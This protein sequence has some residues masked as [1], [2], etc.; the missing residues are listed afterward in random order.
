MDS[1]L[2]TWVEFSEIP[3]NPVDLYEL[4]GYG[5][6]VPAGEVSEIIEDLIKTAGGNCN[7]RIGYR[8]FDGEI[9]DSRQVRVENIIFAPGRIITSALRDS[10]L[11]AVFTATAGDDFDNWLGRI[12]SEGDIVRSYIASS[13]GSVIAESLVTMLMNRLERSASAEGLSVS[14]NYSPG[15]C[16]WHLGEQKKLLSLLENDNTGIRLNDSCLMI[17]IKSVSGLTGIGRRVVRRAYGCDICRMPDC[18]KNK[19][20]RQR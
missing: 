12:E 11:F 16:D 17:P 2:F 5:D 15:Y 13:L 4:M 7:P 14:N 9:I 8:I 3:F 19:K 18:I 1:S 6:Q 10:E 20:R